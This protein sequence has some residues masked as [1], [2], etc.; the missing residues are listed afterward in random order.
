[1]TTRATTKKQLQELVDSLPDD[2]GYSVYADIGEVIQWMADPL[3]QWHQGGTTRDGQVAQAPW[4]PPNTRY[5]A[6]FQ[7]DGIE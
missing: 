4:Y 7:P 3:R 1:M 5:Y 6:I 2:L